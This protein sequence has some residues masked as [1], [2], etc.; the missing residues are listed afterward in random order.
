MFVMRILNL[1]IN[2]YVLRRLFM[3]APQLPYGSISGSVYVPV[4][5]EEPE[6]AL[7]TPNGPHRVNQQDVSRLHKQLIK[8]FFAFA[9]TN[10]AIGGSMVGIGASSE[11]QG[12][13]LSST[14]FF[15][16]T[17]LGIFGLCMVKNYFQNRARSHDSLSL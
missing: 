17:V 9:A 8:G 2:A 12:L 10:L 5:L 1:T 14:P 15:A 4:P 7:R 16:N 13:T 3:S 11:N 6:G